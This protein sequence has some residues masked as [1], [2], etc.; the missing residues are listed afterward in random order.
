MA[1]NP[2]GTLYIDMYSDH[3]DSSADISDYKGPY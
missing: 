1:L 3:I 2:D